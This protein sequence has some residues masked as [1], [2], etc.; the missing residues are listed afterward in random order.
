MNVKVQTAVENN[1]SEYVQH[2]SN[3]RDTKA[4]F[5]Y[6]R[7]FRNS[8]LPSVMKL[9]NS[10]AKTLPEQ[11]NLFAKFFNSA[12]IIPS[13]PSCPE[14]QEHSVIQ[15][16]HSIET[17]RNL[18]AKL[19]NDLDL[20]KSRGLDLLP[21]VL[22]KLCIESLTPSLY[23]II[24]KALQTCVSLINVNTLLSAQ[25]SKRKEARPR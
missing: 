20:S 22:F 24:Y 8:E 6:Y 21:P 19:C 5:K 1:R 4:L 13:Q 2:L 16:I 23:H 10:V 14:K 3:S 17:D 9:D 25:Y 18:I 11:D 12:F 15:I 7:K